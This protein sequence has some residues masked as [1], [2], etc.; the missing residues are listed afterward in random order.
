MVY[1]LRSPYVLIIALFFLLGCHKTQ[2]RTVELDVVTEVV[3]P[4]LDVAVPNVENGRILEDGPI[5][6]LSPDVLGIH[7]GPEGEVHEELALTAGLVSGEQIDTEDLFLIRPLADAISDLP[8]NEPLRP[9]ILYIDRSMPFR[10]VAQ[11]VHTLRAMGR[12]EMLL[13]ARSPD[14]MVALHLRMPVYQEWEG[15]KQAIRYRTDVTLKW[16]MNG[17]R[18]IGNPQPQGAVPGVVWDINLPMDSVELILQ[19]GRCPLMPRH[20]GRLSGHWSLDELLRVVCQLNDEAFGVTLAPTPDTEFG[21]V[22]HLL[23]MIHQ[24]EDCGISVRFETAPPPR[25]NGARS[26]PEL[27]HGCKDAVLASSAVEHFNEE[28]LFLWQQL[29][30]TT[31]Q[32]GKKKDGQ[33]ERKWRRM[34]LMSDREVE[35]YWREREKSPS[36]RGVVSLATVATLQGAAEGVEWVRPGLRSIIRPIKECYYAALRRRGTT[37]GTIRMEFSVNPT[38]SVQNTMVLDN[39]TMDEELSQC[40]FEL[41]QDLMF[42]DATARQTFEVAWEFKTPN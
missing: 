27:T 29:Y 40:V 38:G 25:R 22:A 16:S 28:S 4:W 9:M 42:K 20:R 10:T 6:W 32:V 35:Q 31:G 7:S 3:K 13:A 36:M 14:N 12:M 17:V 41:T 21:E 2:P 37:T 8:K 19:P 18:A 34:G 15:T 39:S 26:V 24:P 33:L 23:E 30:G 5:V 11:V 1:R